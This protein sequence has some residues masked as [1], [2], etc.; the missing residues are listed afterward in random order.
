M[1]ANL[2]ANFD[3]VPVRV[4]SVHGSA[5]FMSHDQRE[6]SRRMEAKIYMQVR[7]ADTGVLDRKSVV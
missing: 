3:I 5:G 7:T 6:L 2:I 4:N 1:E